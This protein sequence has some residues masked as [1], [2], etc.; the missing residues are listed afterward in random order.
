MGILKVAI[1]QNRYH[2]I[3]AIGTKFFL[4]D[5]RLFQE[6]SEAVIRMAEVCVLRIKN[7]NKDEFINILK[8]KKGA[9]F[10]FLGSGFSRHYLDTPQWDGILQMFAPY[11]LAQYYSKLNTKSLIK[12][13]TEIAKDVTDEFWNLDESD[14][15]KKA[16]Q[17]RITDASSVLKFKISEYLRKQSLRDFP[18]EYEEEIHILEKLSIDGIITT[19]WDDTAERLFPQ[20][21][22]YIGQE[23]LIFSSTYSVGEI[24]KIHGSY[25]E[26]KSLVLTE[27]DYDDFSKKYPYLAAK[28]I[29]IF[30]EHPVVFLGY[31]ISD[32]NIQEILQSIV[33]CLDNVNIQKLQ[34]NLI[35]VE[36]IA[37]ED[38][39]ITIERQ[40]I[41]MANKV[42][43]P[44]IKIKTHSFKEVY[45]LLQYYERSI[46]ANVLREY[47]KQFFEIVQSEKPEKQI[48]VLPSTVVD[49][50]KTI[51][52]VYGFGAINKFRSAVGYRGIQ[53]VEL[54]KDV[55]SENT[56]LNA[57]QVLTDA[58]PQLTKSSPKAFIPIYKYLSKV[59][60]N[61][62]QN[63]SGNKLGVNYTLRK[64]CDFQSYSFSE[65]EKNCCLQEV[66]EK[67]SGKDVWKAVALIPYLNIKEEE[68]PIL[69][70]FINKNFND[71]L[72][73]RNN[74]STY[75]RQLI[76]FY[77]WKKYGWE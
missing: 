42:N 6:D 43:L 35:F 51:Q 34:D 4:C 74:Y 14:E 5:S 38:Y 9:P 62:D 63:Y 57:E 12:V 72:I 60:I 44:V 29:T 8:N 37:E 2:A 77:D 21:T 25:R 56:D 66:I 73:K 39:A 54:L 59:G 41:M 26:P 28:L 32:S 7:M 13:A 58:Y 31:S 76:C 33:V 75:M 23:Q 53:A 10:L 18:E 49:K 16:V 15:F 64:G 67:Y 24:Y 1:A 3:A 50:D 45:E 40:D 55:L 52:V 65:D 19:N 22:P 71:F 69:C 61:S 68:L 30:I 11:K 20:F 27:D 47:K 36:W 46:P 48:Y 17:D 70:N